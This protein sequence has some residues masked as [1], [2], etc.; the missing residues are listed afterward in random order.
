MIFSNLSQC[1]QNI[2]GI[3]NVFAITLIRL[4]HNG[5]NCA[6]LHSFFYKILSIC[7]SSL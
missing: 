3:E 5:A 2:F 6:L 7:K 1:R 4:G